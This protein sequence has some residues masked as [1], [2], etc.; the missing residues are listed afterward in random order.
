MHTTLS[1]SLT[2]IV[3]TKENER[4]QLGII[5]TSY[6]IQPGGASEQLGG[7]TRPNIQNI[8]IRGVWGHAPPGK[9]SNLHALR[10]NLEASETKYSH[11]YNGACDSALNLSAIIQR[12]MHVLIGKTHY[13]RIGVA[14]SC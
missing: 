3:Y 4:K 10:L 7:G 5:Y 14:S 13:V 8:L 6:E 9:L 12:L 11:L 2:V 1:Q